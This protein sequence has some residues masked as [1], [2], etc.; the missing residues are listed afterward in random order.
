MGSFN[1]KVTA[2]TWRVDGPFREQEKQESGENE[3]LGE[4]QKYDF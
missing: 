4:I 1:T 2:K 3:D